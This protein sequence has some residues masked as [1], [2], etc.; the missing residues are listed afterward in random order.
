MVEISN[1]LF[2]QAAEIALT[3][4]KR[5]V[6]VSQHTVR[7]RYRLTSKINLAGTKAILIIVDKNSE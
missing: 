1:R 6:Q 2:Q 5:W 4:S 7:L 3:S